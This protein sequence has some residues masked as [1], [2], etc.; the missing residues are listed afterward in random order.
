MHV[1]LNTVGKLDPSSG[2][3]VLLSHASDL[4]EKQG[5]TLGD[6]GNYISSTALPMS[7]R[8]LPIFRNLV[9]G[10]IEQVLKAGERRVADLAAVMKDEHL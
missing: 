8:L 10:M 6:L 3:D 4:L 1:M 2:A 7:E 9:K 5:M